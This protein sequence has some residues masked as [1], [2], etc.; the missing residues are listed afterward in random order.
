MTE[1]LRTLEKEPNAN[2]QLIVT[3]SDLKEFAT[4]LIKELTEEKSNSE[5]MEKTLLTSAQVTQKLQC[6]PST[7][8]RWAKVGYLVPIR[9][10]VKKRYRLSDI[11][12]IL[13]EKEA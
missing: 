13:N 3:L 4:S 1:L 8:W 11:N 2:V 7:L 5:E 6:D 12:K 10:G 9:V